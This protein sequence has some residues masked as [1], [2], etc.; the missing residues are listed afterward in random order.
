MTVPEK[1]IWQY[2]KL[3]RAH[4]IPSPGLS[5]REILAGHGNAVQ[6]SALLHYLQ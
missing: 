5:P 1:R 3:K 6:G 4:L 2:G